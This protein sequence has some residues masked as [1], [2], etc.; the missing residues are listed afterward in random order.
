MR[1]SATLARRALSRRRAVAWH[2]ALHAA[3]ARPARPDPDGAGRQVSASIV[4]MDIG[5]WTALDGLD[6]SSL[7]MKKEKI[8]GATPHAEREA[9]SAWLGLRP[10][11]DDPVEKNDAK[12]A[13]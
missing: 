13:R 5:F 8:I 11:L 2:G 4:P 10:Y 3:V 7:L 9:A 1:R 12:D 6:G